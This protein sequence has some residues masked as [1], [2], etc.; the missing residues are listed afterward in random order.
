MIQW[1]RYVR[2]KW[3]IEDAV[4][5]SMDETYRQHRNFSRFGTSGL[6][7]RARGERLILQ[8]NMTLELLELNKE[9]RKGRPR[10]LRY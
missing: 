1:W 7:L 4:A 6:I 9:L 5:A 8:C 2:L 10:W 3:M